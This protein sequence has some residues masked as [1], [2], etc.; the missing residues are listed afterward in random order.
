MVKCSLCDMEFKEND[1][2]L[3]ERKQAH[4][5]FHSNCK[6]EKRNTTEGKVEWL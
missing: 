6:A 4:E 3:N 5:R 1:P 2:L